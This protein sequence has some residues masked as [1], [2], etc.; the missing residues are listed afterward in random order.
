M[1]RQGGS[2]VIAL[3]STAGRGGRMQ[4]D[5]SKQPERLVSAHRHQMSSRNLGRRCR[6]EN[7]TE[8]LPRTLMRRILSLVCFWKNVASSDCSSTL[9]RARDN[10]SC[11][12]GDSEVDECQDCYR[13]SSHDWCLAANSHDIVPHRRGSCDV[14]IKSNRKKKNITLKPQTKLLG[15][16]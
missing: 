14:L 6:T 7:R 11:E 2:S 15:L 1:T 13:P 9:S 10:L 5:V 4:V 16:F 12:R 8:S 3:S